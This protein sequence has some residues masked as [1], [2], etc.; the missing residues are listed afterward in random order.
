MR[1]GLG[2][3][4]AM[5]PIGHRTLLLCLALA[6]AP[7][8]STS[9]GVPPGNPLAGCYEAASAGGD[10]PYPCDLAVQVARDT[11]DPRLLAGTLA[12][13]AMVL[14]R[15]QRFEPALRDLNDAVAAAPD[16]ADLHGNRGNLLLRMGRAT[17]ALA[18]H[19]RAV[20]LAPRDPAGYYNRAFAYQALGDPARAAAD[21]ETARLLL[22][23]GPVRVPGT[24]APAAA[25]G[26]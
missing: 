20:A 9:A 7:G 21:V 17:E 2:T 26:G 16:Q 13:R 5:N 4:R 10:D 3:L 6:V 24:G 11:G 1:G 19:D 8:V 18:A 14:T 25:Q 15:L 22:S 23:S 12:N